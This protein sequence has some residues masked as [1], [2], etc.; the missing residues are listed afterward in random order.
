MRLPAA[1]FLL[2]SSRGAIATCVTDLDCSLNGLCTDGICACDPA[3]AGAACDTLQLLPS[4]PGD[5]TCDPSLNGTATGFTTTWGGIP[6]E[7]AV[8]AWHLHVAEMALHC[9]MCSWSSQSQIA[10]YKSASLLGPYARVDTS[11]GAWG[12]NPVVIA[13]PPATPDN[14]SYL[15]WH[16]GIGCDSA[17]VHACDYDRIPSC[18]NGYTPPHPQK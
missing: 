8:G 2:A 5:G 14:V 16:I 18:S 11:V 7:D 13:A 1:L 6:M 12:H 10:H 9:G 3:W 17:G 15:M 4:T